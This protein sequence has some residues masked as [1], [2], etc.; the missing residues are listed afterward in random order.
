M[1]RPAMRGKPDIAWAGRAGKVVAAC[2]SAG[3]G[4]V[5]IFA[6]ARSYGLAGTPQEGHLALGGF[7]AAWVGVAP[8]ADTAFAVD[9]TLHL[10]ATAKDSHGSALV[11]APIRWTSDDPAVATVDAAGTVVAHA[12]GATSIA[13]TVGDRVG[14]AR[15]VVAQR[16][17]AV[18]IVDGDS[19]V[20]EG[21]RRQ[22]RAYAVDARGYAIHGGALA[23]WSSADTAI[24]TIDSTG[25]V[26]GI[27]PGRVTFEAT[28]HGMS[29]RTTLD[30]RAVP[31]AIA[32]VS[33]ADQRATTEAR[34]EQPVVVRVLSTRGRPVPNVTVRF[35]ASG[36]AGRAEPATAVTDAEGRARTWWTLGALPGRQR[37]LA[38]ANDVDSAAVVSAEAE[39][40]AA[41]LRATPMGPGQ[42]GS[43]GEPLA[44]P[45]GVLLT[46][47]LGRPI[48]DLAVS[49][50]TADGGSV[51]PTAARTDSLGEATV[52]WTLGPRT[53]SQQLRALVG[54]SRV[55][56]PVIVTAAAR[57]GAPAAAAVAGGDLQRGTVAA[58]LARGVVVRVRDRAGNAVPGAAVTFEVADGTLA[59]TVLATDSAG[60]VTARW[61]LGP[62]A[63]TQRLVAHVA[64]L[65]APLAVS[66]RARPGPA[67]GVVFDTAAAVAAAA[68]RTG[69]V[70]VLLRVTD[71]FGNPVTDARVRLAAGHGAGAPAAVVTD[72]SG[73]ARVRWT[74]G[75]AGGEQ[76]LAATVGR[77]PLGTLVVHTAAAAGK[78]P[79]AK[80]ASGGK[81][82]P[83]PSRGKPA[84][85]AAA[86]RRPR[87]R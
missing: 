26:A 63:G 9:D 38:S 11:G 13:V 56:P 70:P 21:A 58:P 52:R 51:S 7:S 23:G 73:R 81:A 17:V 28:M 87:A 82:S 18:R 39:P 19:V 86:P 37:L 85:T 74:L 10:V 60:A 84:R 35:T 8:A 5:S 68:K 43:E 76:T 80:P 2:I 54:G 31:G 78:A 32:L 29:A 59:D 66:A 33:G 27:A 65:D 77:E 61:T 72:T 64:G 42:S 22:L 14:R 3:T 50:A 75:A 46:D 24:A 6:F 67:A 30:V 48:V 83:P 44:E 45:V 25:M 79:A 4:L 62:R 53:G 41:N 1:A 16:P 69:P 12:A 49:W 40:T 34:L 55:I 15:I 71:A 57:P 47:S 20:G 36:I